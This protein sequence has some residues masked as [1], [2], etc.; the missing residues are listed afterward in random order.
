MTSLGLT[1]DQ[2]KIKFPVG[3]FFNGFCDFIDFSVVASLDQA[4]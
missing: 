4:D 3:M 1:C 2:V